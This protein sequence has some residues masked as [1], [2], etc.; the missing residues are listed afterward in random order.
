MHLCS[1]PVLVV[2]VL[3][4]QRRERLEA[5]AVEVVADHAYDG[6]YHL[7]Y[8][9]KLFMFGSVAAALREFPATLVALDLGHI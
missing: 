2:A 8:C 9:P 7:F 4:V 5:V 1:A 3:L 6:L